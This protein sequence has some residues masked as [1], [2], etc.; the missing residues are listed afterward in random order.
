M[1]IKALEALCCIN[2]ISGDED[3]V[4]KYIINEING[5]AE[6]ITVDNMGNIIV[7]KKGKKT[8]DKKLM[9]SAHMDEVGF[10]V[11]AVT[12]DGFLKF[13]EVGGIDRRV[14]LGKAVTVGRF[15]ICGVVCAK[16]IHLLKGDAVSAIPAY[17]EMYIDIGANSKE[18]ALS[19][20][21][22]GDS[23]CFSSPFVVSENTVIG[24]ALDDRAGCQIMIEMIQS[25]LEYDTYFTFVVQEE[26]G[27]RGSKCAA[28]ALNPDYAIVIEST[29][30]A[31]IPNVD[32][33]KKVCFVGEGA[34]ISFM[35]R[36]TVYD[37]KLVALALECGRK[38]NVK[39]QLKQAVAGGNDAGSIHTS[40]AGVPTVAVSVPCRY[41][42][43]CSGLVSNDD[44]TA[45]ET[46]VKELSHCILE[47]DV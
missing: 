11:T 32:E 31:D 10:I 30:A 14:V 17:D 21:N 13:T 26:V 16:P 15:N 35:D 39:T 33:S 44:L 20:I 18:D 9:I 2:G 47:S 25:D 46:T 27:L 42:H 28:F 38:A 7:F 23:I 3:N 41:L 45:V 4:R 40:Q 29:T 24:K 5:H 37:K 8:S 43:S 12:S 19:Q 34:V 1:N 6:N 22:L 36:C